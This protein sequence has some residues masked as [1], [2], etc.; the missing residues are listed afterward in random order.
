[1]ANVSGSLRKMTIEG[2]SFRVAAD[3]NANW[4]FS[5][6]ENSVIATSGKGMVKKMKRVAAVEGLVLVCDMNEVDQLRSLV[7]GTDELKFSLQFAD[8][9]EAKA[10]GAVECENFE[11]EEGRISTNL[12]PTGGWTIVPA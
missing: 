6:F 11:N 12:Y 9:S 2:I 1:M 4:T 8:G 5:E 10:K 7:E 3:A